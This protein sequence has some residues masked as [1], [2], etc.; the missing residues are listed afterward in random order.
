MRRASLAPAP[1]NGRGWRSCSLFSGRRTFSVIRIPA[2]PK[3][4]IDGDDLMPAGTDRR[5][6]SKSQASGQR[7]TQLRT[8]SRLWRFMLTATCSSSVM[9][10]CHVALSANRLNVRVARKVRTF[11]ATRSGAFERHSSLRNRRCTCCPAA[12][13]SFQE[14]WGVEVPKGEAGVEVEVEPDRLTVAQA[15]RAAQP[16]LATP[17]AAAASVAAR[18]VSRATVWYQPPPCARLRSGAAA[19]AVAHACAACLA[20]PAAAPRMCCGRLTRAAANRRLRSAK[21]PRTASASQSS[22]PPRTAPS[23]RW[24]A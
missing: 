21:P 6:S 11:N 23:T 18:R 5:W 10:P 19:R 14:F 22:S 20:A 2:E 15:R 1:R 9:V 3:L 24:A 16:A 13:A 17:A 7:R 12:M 4:D 8:W